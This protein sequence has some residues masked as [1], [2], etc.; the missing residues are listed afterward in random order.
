MEYKT[1]NQSWNE[2]G[3]HSCDKSKWET[4]TGPHEKIAWVGFRKEDPQTC[5]EREGS[6]NIKAQLTLTGCSSGE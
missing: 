4:E 6:L 2:T 1:Q 5:P 3:T